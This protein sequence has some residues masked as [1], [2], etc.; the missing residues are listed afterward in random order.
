[1]RSNALVH[2]KSLAEWSQAYDIPQWVIEA[3]LK[4]GLYTVD[5]VGKLWS[6]DEDILTQ[7]LV[8]ARNTPL[9]E[10]LWSRLNVALNQA[11]DY[12]TRLSKMREC[13]N[14]PLRELQ[15]RQRSVSEEK[16]FSN[17]FPAVGSYSRSNSKTFTFQ[18]SDISNKDVIEPAGVLTKR[19]SENKQDQTLMK[20][21]SRD[22]A[23]APP[24]LSLVAPEVT[25]QPVTPPSNDMNDSIYTIS[26]PNDIAYVTPPSAS[27]LPF[28][29]DLE[30]WITQ[31]SISVEIQQSIRELDVLSL[32]EL[33]KLPEDVIGSLGDKL[34]AIPRKKFLS[35]MKE[36]KTPPS[37]NSYSPY[38]DEQNIKVEMDSTLDISG[39]MVICLAE[40]A[41][42][43]E[44]LMKE[45][46]FENSIIEGLINQTMSARDQYSEKAFEII[47]QSKVSHQERAKR[48]RKLIQEKRDAL[49]QPH[50]P[51]ERIPSLPPPE[52]VKVNPLVKVSFQP[53][54]ESHSIYG[55]Y[56]TTKSHPDYVSLKIPVQYE[57]FESNKYPSSLLSG[58]HPADPKIGK[59][60][61][62][63]FISFSYLFL[64][65][66]SSN[67]KA[68]ITTG[69]T[70]TCGMCKRLN[71][72]SDTK[73]VDCFNSRN[74][75][76]SSAMNGDRFDQDGRKIQYPE[77]KY[78]CRECR[79][80]P[81][82]DLFCF[83]CIG[84]Y[85]ARYQKKYRGNYT[86]CQ[87]CQQIT[88][89][90]RYCMSC[91]KAS[92]SDSPAKP[93]STSS[94]ISTFLG[95]GSGTRNQE[96]PPV[97][98]QPLNKTGP[99]GSTFPQSI[100]CPS[101]RFVVPNARVCT[102]CNFRFK[103]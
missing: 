85:E 10:V 100:H 90:D 91:M 79:Q 31:N 44:Q 21:T 29:P 19:N 66:V 24:P 13:L 27:P 49:P 20:Q 78:I 51:L 53:L 35:S 4:Y 87:K 59:P 6:E 43:I 14:S 74:G 93:A 32:E 68:A 97:T 17:P 36:L 40:K 94:F 50:P 83:D 96:E 73:C 76:S 98:Q 46:E 33:M 80:N 101:C 37:T 47:N 25:P 38:P 99:K 86:K 54:V 39:D 82:N 2:W 75:K 22:R 58:A 84:R 1:M 15:I 103:Y 61:V 63:F 18:T 9:N 89:F 5:A 8:N 88:I 92:V 71:S 65:E 95:G 55:S 62:A 57:A 26:S 64:I 34:K 28:H 7:L 48:I 102:Q 12:Y 23:I 69:T 3:F 67:Q 72:I 42:S 45:L 52:V 41:L 60:Y 81:T 16:S 77:G 30:A 56:N 70:W 11:A